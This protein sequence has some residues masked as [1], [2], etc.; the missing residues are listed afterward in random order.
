MRC[1]ILIAFP[2]LVASCAQP[3][4]SVPE[5]DPVSESTQS[6]SVDTPEDPPRNVMAMLGPDVWMH[7]YTPTEG[8]PRDPTFWV[9]ADSGQLAEGEKVWSVQGARAVIYRDDEEDLV[10]EALEGEVDEDRKV[11]ELRGAVRLTVGSLIVDLED[12]LW[13]NEK[14]TATSNHAVHLVDANMRLDAKSLLIR[15]DEGV[16]ILGE[17]SGYIRLTE[18]TP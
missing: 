13:E 16:L 12:L 1:A 10:V 15:R 5:S 9:H 8:E 14:G 6:P 11:A 17:G 4:E 3:P 18:P 2:L 7:D